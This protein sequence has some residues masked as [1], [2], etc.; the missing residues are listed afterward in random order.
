MLESWGVR[1]EVE[2]EVEG[3]LEVLQVGS[4]NVWNNKEEPRNETGSRL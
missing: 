2:I 3:L 4:S 1:R